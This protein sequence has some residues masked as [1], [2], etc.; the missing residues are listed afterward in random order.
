MSLTGY[1]VP[2]DNARM[3]RCVARRVG[4]RKVES[5]RYFCFLIGFDAIDSLSRD[6]A[7][8]DQPAREI[9][10]RRPRSGGAPVFGFSGSGWAKR[11]ADPSTVPT[12]GSEFSLQQL[13]GL[14]W[15]H[16]VDQS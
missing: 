9:W 2:A 4:C 5:V 3:F 10:N 1:F 16:T 6:A 15:K 14:R 7:P 11:L 13:L 12:V 8:R